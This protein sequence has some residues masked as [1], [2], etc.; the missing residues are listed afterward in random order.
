MKKL[1]LL[2]TGLLMGLTT[3]T[4]TE[5]VK[6]SSLNDDLIFNRY[7]LNEPIQF[8]ERGVEFLIFPDGS[9]DFNT[10]T[11]GN[12]TIHDDG[13]YRKTNTKRSRINRTF[14]TNGK[15]VQFTSPR[16]GVKI[17]HDRDGKVR[18]VGNVFI[19]Y[20]QYDQVRRLG[21]VYINYNRRG[22]LTQV[23]GL[24]LKYNRNGRVIKIFGQVNNRNQSYGQVGFTGH[25]QNHSGSEHQ[26]NNNWN[27]EYD[28][29][30]YKKEDKVLKQKKL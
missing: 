8:K 9:F 17:T 20:N 14:G 28:N 29:Y 24:H 21:S 25:N 11:R 19:N 30:Y 6:L 15:Q 16:R 3:V 4:A 1:V 23:G 2:F 10:N 13:Y 22:V 12:A 18:R 5:Q 26:Q 7:N 27:T